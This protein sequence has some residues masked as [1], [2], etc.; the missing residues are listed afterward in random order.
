MTCLFLIPL[1][2]RVH[3]VPHLKAAKYGIYETRGLSCDNASSI[4]QDVL[5]ID[6][7]LHR[8]GFVKIQ[9]SGTVNLATYKWKN[10]LIH[11]LSNQFN[12][13]QLVKNNETIGRDFS[14]SDPNK[15]HP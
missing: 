12:F 15:N 10:T 3:T 9:S 14:T 11:A 7:L 2:V 4:C 1:L 6:N 5:K 13:Y 8:W